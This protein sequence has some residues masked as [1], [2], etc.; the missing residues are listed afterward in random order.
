MKGDNELA[1]QKSTFIKKYTKAINDGGAAIFAGAGL[2]VP[3]GY[4]SWKELLRPL[5]EEIGLSIDKEH[6]YL[7]IAQYYY[8]KHGNRS[9]I[10]DAVLEA[11]TKDV[12][13]NESLNI[14]TRL[15]ID[16]YW[17]TNYDHLIEEA[18]KENGR[19]PDIKITNENLANNLRDC[20][21]IVY[22]MHGDV[23]FPNNTV[24]IKEDYETYRLNR[25]PFTTILK[26]HLLSKTFLFLGFSFEDPNLSS[27]L[28][29]IKNLLGSNVREHYCLFEEVSIKPKE[30]QNDFLYRKAKQDL[31]VDDLKR[32]GIQ[33]VLLKSYGEIPEILKEIERQC[34]LNNVFISGSMSLDNEQWTID[35]AQTFASGLAQQLVVEGMHVTSGY[36]LGIGSAVITGV[37]NEVRNK[38]YAHFDEYLKLY[39]FP[40]PREGEDFRELWHDYRVEIIRKCGVAVFI[41][42]NKEDAMG[43]RIVANGMIDEF[44]IAKKQGTVVI[45]IAATGDAALQIYDEMYKNKVDYGYLAEYWDK[46]K[47]E[48]DIN[49]LSKMII[50]II[51]KV[52]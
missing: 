37:L 18:L 29:W 10:N 3:S 17:T 35:S 43:N 7:A 38:K 11:F 5:A 33:A 15:P 41:F 34:N 32:Y 22:K 39:P 27:I 28:S 36:G 20:S 48:K 4:V 19:K 42:G 9:G 8:N 25:E 45:P 23:Q 31:I 6:D 24:L 26:G 51:R 46:L 12:K 1:V 49:K 40:Q 47:F 30:E 52:K 13:I 16:T 14:I 2:S 50:E 44:E 21:A